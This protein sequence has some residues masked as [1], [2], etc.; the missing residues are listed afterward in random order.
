VDRTQLTPSIKPFSQ[1]LDPEEVRRQQATER[2][3]DAAD[4]ADLRRLLDDVRSRKQVD[5]DN[6]REAFV[7][8]EEDTVEPDA[9]E[10]DEADQEQDRG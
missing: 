3:F 6:W 7:S 1:P 8:K 2:E 9:V 10:P 5:P 4:A